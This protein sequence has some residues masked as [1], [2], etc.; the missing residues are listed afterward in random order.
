MFYFERTIRNVS[1]V[2]EHEGRPYSRYKPEFELFFEK[3][4]DPVINTVYMQV[5]DYFT[6]VIMQ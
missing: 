4:F 6:F 3:D 2:G 5:R 1:S